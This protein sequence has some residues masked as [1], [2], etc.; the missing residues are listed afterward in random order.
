MNVN[1]TMR[2]TVLGTTVKEKDLGVT[3]SADMKVSE[4]CGIA[5]SKGNQILGL[6]RRNITYKGKKLIIP[7]YKA[8]VRP[9]LEYCIQAWRTPWLFSLKKD[10]RTRGHE[11]K[12]LKDQCRLDIRKHSF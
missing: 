9:H 3:I 12:L 1:Y 2:D 5:A 11:V 8:I 10:S 7:L 6:I 4:Q